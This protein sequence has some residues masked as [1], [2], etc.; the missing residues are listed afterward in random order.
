MLID[1]KDSFTWHAIGQGKP[2]LRPSGVRADSEQQ[3]WP[4][5]HAI[6]IEIRL[7]ID[8]RHEAEYGEVRGARIE[9]NEK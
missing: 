9:L 8:L 3:S 1:G 7:L 4:A 2:V 6:R 5:H